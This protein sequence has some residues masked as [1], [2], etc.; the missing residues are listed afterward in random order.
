VGEDLG[1][2]LVETFSHFSELMHL[3]LKIYYWDP[4]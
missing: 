1:R 3:L 4:S 2:D